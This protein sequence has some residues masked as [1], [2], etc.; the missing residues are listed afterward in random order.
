MN[1][2]MK[3]GARLQEGDA[4]CPMC[5]S[6]VEELPPQVPVQ[7]IQQ[8]QQP[9]QPQQPIQSQTAPQQ[10]QAAYQR[11][12]PKA[13]P[14]SPEEEYEM[15]E[16]VQQSP[17]A[18]PA[19]S[20]NYAQSRPSAPA[21]YGR[22]QPANYG[23]G[24]QQANSGYGQQR[25]YYGQNRPVAA[26]TYGRQQPANYGQPGPKRVKNQG[27][28]K[29]LSLIFALGLLVAAVGW[30]CGMYLDRTYN[31]TAE[32]GASKQQTR[33]VFRA[34][35]RESP[36]RYRN[37]ILESYHEREYHG[38]DKELADSQY[39]SIYKAWMESYNETIQKQV[40]Y[41]WYIVRIGA[42]SDTLLL[43][44]GIAAGA[45]LLLWLLLGG[46]RAGL[47]RTTLM[48][49]LVMVLI[50]IACILLAV[51]LISPVNLAEEMKGVDMP[52]LSI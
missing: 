45:A 4:F 50:W 22:Q 15:V 33:D 40:G 51:F 23:Y 47:S 9:T 14:V 24:Q 5:G 42:Y 6:K 34:V 35:V 7:P 29:F 10:Q 31:E 46:T 27:L 1:F 19:A 38:S 30:G 48:P 8:P 41:R 43:I 13:I 3:C 21:A 39:D 2:C 26:N 17:Y 25:G 44:G 52:Q 20:A 37:A 36:E 49:L 18:R 28:L 32:A 11:E 16:P 12:I